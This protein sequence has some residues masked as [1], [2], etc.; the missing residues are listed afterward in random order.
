MK[1]SKR[2]VTFGRTAVTLVFLLV[3]C[4]A[5]ESFRLLPGEGGGPGVPFPATGG[6]GSA[7]N[8]GGQGSAGGSFS[9]GGM[10]GTGGASVAEGASGGASH[11]TGGA[12]TGGARTGGSDTGGA[13]T[14][15]AATGAAGTG[16]AGPSA[17]TYQAENAV[18][19]GGTVLETKNGGYHGAGY[20]AFPTTG[21]S[22]TFTKVDGGAGGGKTLT[23]RSALGTTMARSGE[24]VV[25]GVT[26][27]ITFNITGTWNMWMTQDVS[28]T[29]TPGLSN[30]IV[31]RSTGQDLANID[32]ITLN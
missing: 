11:G 23:I 16:G 12:E 17:V 13:G 32:E 7:A 2:A 29:L 10:T 5:P 30:T 28:V 24:L 27:S 6:Q 4:A 14:G 19:A 8:T 22:V 25:N 20:E 3:G 21:G 31:L 26:S 9:T 15:G 1:H 18:A